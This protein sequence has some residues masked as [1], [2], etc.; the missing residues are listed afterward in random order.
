VEEDAAIVAE[1]APH[2]TKDLEDAEEILCL[3]E[4]MSEDWRYDFSAANDDEGDKISFN[5]EC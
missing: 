5:F 4:E 2:L 1:G 3:S